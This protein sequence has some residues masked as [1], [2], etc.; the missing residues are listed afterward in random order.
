MRLNSQMDKKM[1]AAATIGCAIMF[2]AGMRIS[3]SLQVQSNLT[4]TAPQVGWKTYVDPEGEFSIQYP[5]D[6]QNT[7]YPGYKAQFSTKLENP[8]DQYAENVKIAVYYAKEEEGLEHY[9]QTPLNL[10]KQDAKNARII[11]KENI[12]FAGLPAIKTTAIGEDNRLKMK[13]T[14]IWAQ[15][16]N[17]TYAVSYAAEEDSYD[18]YLPQAQKIMA[19]MTTA[20]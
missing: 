3:E 4:M 5:Q 12:T 16:E 17:R 1:L 18:K 14:T 9:A 20:G 2:L 13:V 19:S 15:G 8:H 6:W 10:G 7:T 11:A